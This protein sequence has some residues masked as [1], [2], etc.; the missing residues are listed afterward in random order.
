MA[1]GPQK[2]TVNKNQG[3]MAISEHSYAT[4]ACSG[5]P[6]LIEVLENDFKYNFIKIIEAFKEKN[7]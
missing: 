6:N 1:K 7:E 5:Y 4:K 3:S 2:N